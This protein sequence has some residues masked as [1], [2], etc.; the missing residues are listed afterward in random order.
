MAG[1]PNEHSLPA[2][3]GNKALGEI[4]V[5]HQVALLKLG[6]EALLERESMEKE[7]DYREWTRRFEIS[8]HES[9]PLI[10]RLD[11]ES[12]KSMNQLEYGDH[13]HME[14][15]A[16]SAASI[17]GGTLR[18]AEIQGP[19]IA[20][21]PSLSIGVSVTNQITLQVALTEVEVLRANA[22]HAGANEE[23]LDRKSVV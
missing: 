18:A 13:T 1:A 23:T 17:I 12:A 21:G 22:Q 2:P 3:E 15:A 16:F 11:P 19:V 6:L 9:M 5:Q 10:R 4:L 14:V 7:W 20:A 8:R